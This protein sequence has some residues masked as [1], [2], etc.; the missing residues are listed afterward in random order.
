VRKL[1][2]PVV[3]LILFFLALFGWYNGQLSSLDS[4]NKDLQVFVV[5]KG[6]GVSEIA[7]KLKQ[8]KLIKSEL[9]F[10]VY[11]KQNSL[12]DKLQAGSFKLSPSMSVAEITKELQGGSL[13]TWVTLLEGWRVEEIAEKLNSEL[14]IKNSEFLKSSKEGYMFPDT[15]L[16]PKEATVDLITKTMKDNFD[17]KYTGELQNKIKKNGLTPAQGVI[18]ASI[19]ERE[20]RSSDVRTKVASILLKRFK[21]GMGLNTDATIQYALG[22]QSSEKSWWKKSLTRDDLKIDSEYNTYIHAG[23]PP[24]PICNP[25]VSSLEA[26]A[27]ADSSTPYLYYYH[28]SKGNSY[29]GKTLEEHNENVANHR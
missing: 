13:D 6:A 25:S 9:V 15:Y 2:V 19:V 3:I 24:T 18:L 7:N 17:K 14:G 16:F 23:L 1:I 5:P 10:K 20:A 26:V 4:S 11:L 12:A 27:N 21:I 29:Y 8:E 28:D 22:Y